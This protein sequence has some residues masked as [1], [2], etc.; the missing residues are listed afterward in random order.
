M[1]NWFSGKYFRH[2]PAFMVYFPTM[3]E[4]KLAA[5]WH[6]ELRRAAHHQLSQ[7]VMSQPWLTVASIYC[8]HPTKHRHLSQPGLTPEHSSLYHHLYH[9]QQ[10][11][12][13][14][15]IWSGCFP[16]LKP[17]VGASNITN[18][19]Y[20]LWQTRHFL[21]KAAFGDPLQ[22]LPGLWLC[23][24]V[25]ST[26]YASLFLS[27]FAHTYFLGKVCIPCLSPW[28][29]TYKFSRPTSRIPSSA[30]V[31]LIIIYFLFT[32]LQ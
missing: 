22:S 9:H 16:N 25:L 6:V 12:W 2:L 31:S 21:L 32:L 28:L 4:F 30:K 26:P 23:W 15:N 24:I 27:D 17:S 10:N 20:I 11:L 19:K 14:T 7:A 8:S 13:K 29:I 5:R 3:V 1:F 18:L